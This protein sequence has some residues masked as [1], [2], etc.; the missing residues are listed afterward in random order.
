M[1]AFY[2]CVASPEIL[3]CVFRRFYTSRHTAGRA[4]LLVRSQ[5]LPGMLPGGPRCRTHSVRQLMPRVMHA[6]HDRPGF[7]RVSNALHEGPGFPRASV[8]DCSRC[9]RRTAYICFNRK[10][11]FSMDCIPR[12]SQL[13]DRYVRFCSYSPDPCSTCVALTP[14]C[15]M[16]FLSF[17]PPPQAGLLIYP[18]SL[19]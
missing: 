14:V 5:I 11:R 19:S 9:A 1:W 13:P 12:K 4:A 17:F 10:V 7:P 8:C 16:F 15:N 2:I 18:G 6:L 3:R